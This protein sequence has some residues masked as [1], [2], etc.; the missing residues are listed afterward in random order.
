MSTGYRRTCEAGDWGNETL[1]DDLG[2]YEDGGLIYETPL[3]IIMAAHSQLCWGKP[4]SQCYNVT[5]TA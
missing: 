2:T 1:E 4:L 5:R 3:A